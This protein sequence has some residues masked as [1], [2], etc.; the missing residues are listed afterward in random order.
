MSGLSSRLLAFGKGGSLRKSRVETSKSF[1]HLF[2]GGRVW[3]RV[4]RSRGCKGRRSRLP[5]RSALDGAH[6]APAPL[7]SPTPKRGD[8]CPPLG[9]AQSPGFCLWKGRAGCHRARSRGY[10]LRSRLPARSALNGAHRAPAPCAPSAAFL[11]PAA[12]VK[13]VE[14]CST[15]RKFF[16][17]NLTK[18]FY[19]PTARTCA[20]C[21]HRRGRSRRSRLPPRSV[22]N[23][24]HWAP[25]P[26]SA[27]RPVRPRT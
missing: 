7:P 22:F 19:S 13:A 18:N 16:E 25:T 2:K 3:D 12:P 6:R 24:A 21:R 8:G 5:A 26:Q 9:V 23:G 17:K 14:L 10:R 15:P 11:P 1:V 27:T 20:N 4:P